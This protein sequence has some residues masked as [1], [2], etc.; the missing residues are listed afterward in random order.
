MLGMTST[1]G[2]FL[3]AS[4]AGGEILP[5][6][7]RGNGNVRKQ[8]E[9]EVA[10]KE[11]LASKETDILTKTEAKDEVKKRDGS[12]VLNDVTAAGENVAKA[13]VP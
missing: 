7:E 3:M 10:K 1:T 9:E 6:L 12:P 2:E 11:D 13:A 8:A 4:L 5:V